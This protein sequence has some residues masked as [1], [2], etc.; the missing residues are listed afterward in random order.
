MDNDRRIIRN[1]FGVGSLTL[2]CAI[3]CA[4][5]L[6]IPKYSFANSSIKIAMITAKS[7]VAGPGNIISFDGARFA[8][9]I[10]N[11]EG[12]IL[13]RKVELLEYDNK[14]TP[15]GSAEAARFAIED[16]AIAVVGCNWSSHSLAMAKVLQKEG[17]P[18]VTHMSTNEAVT[19]VGDYIFRICYTDALQ[20]SGLARYAWDKLEAGKAVILVNRERAYS[21]GLADTFTKTFESLGGEIVWR[22]EYDMKTVS[23]AKM[24]N[25]VSKYKP[26][27]L[28]VPG[29]YDDV[30]GFFGVARDLHARWDLLSADGVGGKLYDYLGDKVNGVY[31]ASHWSKGAD[32][33]ESREFIRRY[34]EENGRVPADTVPLVYDSFMV[35][36]DALLR[37]GSTDGH[38]LRKALAETPGYQGVTGTIRFDQNGDPIKPMF[39]NTFRFGGIM[40]L[41]M[42][43][44]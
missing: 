39:L 2:L 5:S 43:Y 10:I 37:A 32:T 16:G 36:R 35:I 19:K 31:Y 44:P 18:M 13:G 24:I 20:G 12:G 41:E 42:V 9:D 21:T 14:S 40:Y 28:F 11:E 27:V 15:E 3:V 17:I 22:G 6:V 23:Y 1:S 29:G 25:E 30:A 4:V 34:E 33:E 7:G 38:K 8:V 26:D